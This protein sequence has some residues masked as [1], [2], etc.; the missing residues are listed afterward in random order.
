MDVSGRGKSGS[1]IANH[2]S[3]ERS[4]YLRMH[5]HNP[6]D[7]Y[8][9]GDEAFEQAKGENRP[10]FLSVGYSACHWCHVMA[11]ESFEDDEVARTLNHSFVSVKVDREERP[12][13]DS[14]YM[15]ACQLMTGAGG[16]PL[17][18]V[19]TP[20]LEP[21]FAGTYIPRSSS[22]MGPGL[23]EIM[24]ELGDQWKNDSRPLVDYSKKVAEALRKFATRRTGGPVAGDP[25]DQATR[26]LERAFDGENGG[27]EVAPKFPSP[28]RLL[29]LLRVY[30]RKRQERAL[31]MVV[32]TL[33]AMRA[34]GIYD[35]VGSGFHRYSTDRRWH[36]PHFEK[37]LYDQAMHVLAYSEAFRATGRES[38]RRTALDVITFVEREMTSPEGGFYSAIGADSEGGEGRFYLWSLGEVEDVL[39]QEEAGLFAKAFGLTEEGNYMD[40][41]TGRRTG[42]NVIHRVTSTDALASELHVSV[43]E[44]VSSLDLSMARLREA[45]SRRARPDLDDKLLSDW[46]GLMIAAC[47]RAGT[48]LDSKHALEMARR[49][50]DHILR[51]MKGWELRHRAV[52]GEVAV[53]G[54]LDDYAGMA[55]GLSELSVA[56][57]DPE[58]SEAGSLADAMIERFRDPVSGALFQTPSGARHMIARMCEG[59]DGASPS[60]NSLAAYALARLAMLTG[61][62]EY[63][64]TGMTVVRAFSEE[65]GGDPAAHAFLALAYDELRP[66]R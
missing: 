16:W 9:W 18:M 57:G 60:G 27:F 41:A 34:G 15:A 29:L 55:W 8:P 33:D 1:E 22:S 40:E 37:M 35:H 20:D 11:H 5:A 56:T 23:I 17:S 7:W 25:L 28:H 2:L 42:L 26:A 43:E 48:V 59:Y 24:T 50:A 4:L 52:D 32:R 53:S 21:F 14:I 58:P 64:E 54:L 63:L 47:A 49:G 13:V 6:V 10:V 19:L 45:R 39:D 51:L 61:S 62:R 44:V 36:L 30:E 12:D 46:N 38:Y 66:F 3:G 31:E 65:L